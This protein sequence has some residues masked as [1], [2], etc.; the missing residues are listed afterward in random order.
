MDAQKSREMVGLV[1]SRAE[2]ASEEWLLVRKR[3]NERPW[4]S[5]VA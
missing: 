5:H 4:E 3:G 2:V 1:G